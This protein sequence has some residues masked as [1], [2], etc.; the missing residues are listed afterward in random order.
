MK[1]LSLLCKWKCAQLLQ[2]KLSLI[3]DLSN[4]STKKFNRSSLWRVDS[5]SPKKRYL[6]N[7]FYQSNFRLFLG[8]GFKF[9]VQKI[10]I[11]TY[12][13]NRKQ[14]VSNLTLNSETHPKH[15]A[16]FE[17]NHLQNIA[18]KNFTLILD[19]FL[20]IIFF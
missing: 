18:Y 15:P 8:T 3:W 17:Y 5:M 6:I 10:Y 1:M 2:I 9:P 4:H 20:K 12:F 16:F 19:L 7:I 11:T 14:T 13:Y